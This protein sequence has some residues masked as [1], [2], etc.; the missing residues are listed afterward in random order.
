MKYPQIRGI[1]KEPIE[2]DESKRILFLDIDGVLN[3]LPWVRHWIGTEEYMDWWDPRMSEPENWEFEELKADPKKHF[4]ITGEKQYLIDRWADLP[5]DHVDLMIGGEY[6]EKRFKKIGI[7]IADKMLSEIRK[8][9]KDFDL[10]VIYLTYWKSEALRLLEPDVNLGPNA[11]L[12][13]QISSRGMMMKMSA[14]HELYSETSLRRPFA[15]LD[16]EATHGYVDK[17]L[18]HVNDYRAKENPEH[19]KEIEELNNIPM[20]LFH[21]DKYWGITKAHI[22][23]LRKFYTDNP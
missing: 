22:R 15:F 14:L 10:Q 19:V 11:Y 18:F 2:F 12:N 7:S 16:D 4:P 13:W 9:T 3:P 5:K 21:V 8:L 23:S 1:D 6:E 20:K 17:K